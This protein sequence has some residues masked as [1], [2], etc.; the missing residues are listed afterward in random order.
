MA[1]DFYS[2]IERKSK[3]EILSFDK[4]FSRDFGIGQ[5]W[6]MKIHALFLIFPLQGFL[7]NMILGVILLL[8]I[9]YLLAID[10]K[11]MDNDKKGITE[12]HVMKLFVFIKEKRISFTEF[13]FKIHMHYP[14]ERK[15]I[16]FLNIVACL[17]LIGFSIFGVM[18]DVSIRFFVLPIVISGFLGFCVYI[19]KRVQDKKYEYPWIKKN[20]E[21]RK[22]HGSNYAKIQADRKKAEAYRRQVKK[23]QE[24]VKEATS[25]MKILGMTYENMTKKTLHTSYLKLA[26]L[27]HPDNQE[28]GDSEKFIECRHAYERLRKK[29]DK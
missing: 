13:L 25:D 5:P 7:I 2:E 17:S 19:G 10:Y 1:Q 14:L 6:G 23:K 8:P 3:K 27:Y 9:L 29:L 26:G 18:M 28:T 15:N 24:A 22:S 20:R 21:R 11:V 16:F 4:I 12:K